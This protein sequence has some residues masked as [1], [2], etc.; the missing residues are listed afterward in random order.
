LNNAET[1]NKGDTSTTSE[2]RKEEEKES[3]PELNLSSVEVQPSENQ[4]L[5]LKPENQ[6]RNSS[7]A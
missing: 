3:T 2:S 1:R 7:I 4:K 6:S 5:E